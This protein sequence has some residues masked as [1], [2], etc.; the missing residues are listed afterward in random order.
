MGRL[1][2]VENHLGGV[3]KRLGGFLGRLGVVLNRLGSVLQAPER[4]TRNLQWFSDFL[5][6][7]S[8]RTRYGRAVRSGPLNHHFSRS[9]QITN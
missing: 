3:L 7:V 9:K 4:E 1:V 6:G 2:G 5:V 8:P